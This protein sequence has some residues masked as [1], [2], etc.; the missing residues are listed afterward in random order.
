MTIRK[1]SNSDINLCSEILIEAYSQE[2]Y[3]EKFDKV[4]ALEY[5]KQKYEVCKNTSF[6]AEVEGRVI[7]FIFWQISSWGDGKQAVLEEIVVR[8]SHQGK[9]VG[10]ELF[11]YSDN[12]IKKLGIKSSMLWAKKDSN[13]IRFHQK[14]GFAIAEDYVVMFKNY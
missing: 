11:K 6:V 2:P 4:Y 3:N 13:I 8:F 7:G 12:I 1:L 14:N 9:G 10:T 5:I